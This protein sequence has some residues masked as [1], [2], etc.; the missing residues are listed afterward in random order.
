MRPHLIL[1]AGVFL[2]SVFAA[3]LYAREDQ[4]LDSAWHFT[5]TDD[6]H[7]MNPGFDDSGWQRVSLPHN[8]GWEEAQAGKDYFRGPGWYRRDLEVKPEVGKR[9]FLRFEAA[10]LVADVYLN[11]KLLGE[12]RGGFGAFCF[13]MTKELSVT[14]PNVLAV[15]VDNSKAADVAPLAGD[16]SVYGGL[17]RPVHLIV[18]GD[19]HFAMT[20]HGSMGVTW[21]QTSVSATE[22]IL[23]VTAEIANSTQSKVPL[24]LAAKIIDAD[25]KVVLSSE[26]SISL[27]P[28]DTAPYPLKV[29]LANPHLWKGRNEPYIYRARVE[30][31]TPN[32][33]VVDSV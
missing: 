12:H 31:R 30:L 18:T 16:F 23:D 8:W 27:A 25:G 21:R 29:R 13:E 5:L 14:G 3:N 2:A 28:R 1:A 10:S 17:Y 7:S 22:A 4:R 33:V 11:G 19:E 32:D 15:R 6:S 26:Q 24:K 20:D 9:Y